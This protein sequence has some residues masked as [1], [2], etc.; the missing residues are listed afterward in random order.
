MEVRVASG[1]K[2]D[3]QRLVR[4]P[5]VEDAE[6]W[7]TVCGLNQREAEELLDWLEANG[8]QN[9]EIA[10]TATGITVRWRR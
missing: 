10:F 7:A 2:D 5:I 9:R 6:G 3:K 4:P 1:E 8:F